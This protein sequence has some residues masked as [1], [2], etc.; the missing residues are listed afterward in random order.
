MHNVHSLTLLHYHTNLFFLS[1]IPG[2]ATSA[3]FLP[4]AGE[5]EEEKNLEEREEK[6]ED[7]LAARSPHGSSCQAEPETHAHSDKQSEEERVQQTSAQHN[8]PD[9][10]KEGVEVP[11]NKKE[12][13]MLRAVVEV[14]SEQIMGTIVY[15]NKSEGRDVAFTQELRMK[16][17]SSAN[18]DT[19]PLSRELTCLAV[20]D[21]DENR[22]RRRRS[23]ITCPEI[24]YDSAEKNRKKKA[25]KKRHLKHHTEP[26]GVV[27]DKVG[28][29]TRQQ[30]KTWETRDATQQGIPKIHNH[31]TTQ[32]ER[33]KRIKTKNCMVWSEEETKLKENDKDI[34]QIEVVEPKYVAT[35]KGMHE[36]QKHSKTC[37]FTEYRVKESCYENTFDQLG[38]MPRVYGKKPTNIPI[39]S[40]RSKVKIPNE[41]QPNQTHQPGCIISR[42]RKMATQ[43][44]SAKT[45][46]LRFPELVLMES[47]IK[48]AG[49]GVFATE[50]F[51]KGDYLSE[52]GGRF[53]RKLEAHH[54]RK[55]NEDTHSR[56]LGRSGADGKVIDGR[57]QQDFPVAYYVDNHMLGSMFNGASSGEKEKV[58]AQYVEIEDLNMGYR[59]PYP[60]PAQDATLNFVNMRLY[61]Q[62][63]RAGKAGEE[64]LVT[65]GSTYDRRHM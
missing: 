41:I 48:G 62:A 17:T 7:E 30:C 2:L 57:I 47:S 12:V 53:M 61:L 60:P 29:L 37:K 20:Q 36:G 44:G 15:D 27:E 9:Q 32:D 1:S 4:P 31:T 25:Q 51:E 23:E 16:C 26:A 19:L 3:Y 39:V 59:H 58:N 24:E 52:Y 11:A 40:S 42:P 50:D 49:Y 65:Y 45:K 28:C 34:D 8:E 18:I 64:F 10:V 43:V 33:K 46:A 56:S 38:K 14:E 22:I 55:M 63:T 21:T 6:G 35:T 13:D 54:L 5:V